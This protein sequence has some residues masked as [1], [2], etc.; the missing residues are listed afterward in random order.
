MGKHADK[1]TYRQVAQLHID[2]LNQSFLATL[3]VTFLAEMYRALDRCDTT[4]LLVEH[5][6]GEI[7]GFVTGGSAM[8]PVYKKMLS[9][10]WVWAVP[11]G[12]SLLSP[13]RFMRVLDILKYSHA[14]NDEALPRH[15]LLSIAVAPHARGSGVSAKLYTQLVA[16]FKSNE[17]LRFK[18]IVG[19]ALAPAHKFY[20]K[21]GATPHSILELHAGEKSTLYVHIIAG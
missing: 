19:E 8:R 13:K 9:R 1:Q 17:V 15:E 3:G 2:N 7:I 12:V 20:T 14:D 16:Y 21:M 5:F 10:I 11:L 6:E 4:V 18:I